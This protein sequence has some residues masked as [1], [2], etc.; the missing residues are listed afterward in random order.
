MK[1]SS[2]Q[3]QFLPEWH[4]TPP[5]AYSGTSLS[6]LPLS[7]ESSNFRAPPPTLGHSQKHTNKLLFLSSLTA[8]PT[9]LE[10]TS[11]WS[12]LLG[13]IRPLGPQS[14][15]HWLSL[16]PSPHVVSSP[17]PTG[18]CIHD[19]TETPLSPYQWPPHCQGRLSVLSSHL[20][21][22]TPA[23]L[24]ASRLVLLTKMWGDAHH[25]RGTTPF[26][27][28]DSVVHPGSGSSSAPIICASDRTTWD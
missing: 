7:P 16:P 10:L 11:L 25:W 28:E 12:R 13:P 9:T 20:L 15:L 18:F 8:W 6:N 21:L 17:L 19:A 26:S 2:P 5:L 1:L 27:V 23:P 22:D 24:T 14:D 4:Q 3:I